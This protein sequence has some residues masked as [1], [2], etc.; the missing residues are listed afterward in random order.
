M[1]VL[2]CLAWGVFGSIPTRVSGRGVLLSD[3]E[4]NFSVAPVT[5]GLVL[6]M[7][8]KPGDHVGA[9]AEIAR[10]E[11]KLLS[12]RIQNAIDQVARLEANLAE[13]RA[14]DAEQISKSDETARRQ[15]AALDE[16]LAAAAVRRDRLRD[17][18]TAYA[19]LRSKGTGRREGGHGPA[20]RIRPDCAR[21]RQCQSQ[22]SRDRGDRPEEARRSRRDRS[23]RRRWR[24]IL[25]KAEVDELRV[26]MTVGS[27][28]KAPIGGV[29][30]E[31]RVGRGDVASAGAVLA[32]IGQDGRTHVEVMALLQAATRASAW[33][34]AWRPTSCR[35]APRRRN[36]ARCAGASRASPTAT[37]RASMSSRSCTTL[38]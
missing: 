9:G 26:E 13:L 25:K 34:S 30:R 24:S 36:T 28:V 18:V 1:I 35:T 8:V 12:A 21:H 23:A 19:G 38:S 31:V 17:M 22:E 7:L 6:E 32:T 2:A 3:K 27:I 29:I 5:S 10:I 15:Q 37:C 4:G 16:N 20:V 33:R 14:V 11:Q